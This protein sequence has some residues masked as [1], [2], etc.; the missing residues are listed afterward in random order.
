MKEYAPQTKNFKKFRPI[1]MNNEFATKTNRFS[2]CLLLFC[3]YIRGRLVKCRRVR[4]WYTTDKITKIRIVFKK[5]YPIRTTS[6][7][8]FRFFH[9]LIYLLTFHLLILLNGVTSYHSNIV[10]VTITS[11]ILYPAH[12][13]SSILVILSIS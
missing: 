5:S 1:L 8:Y 4:P 9:L 7:H 12:F 3:W 10:F 13:H 2:C 11:K 6:E